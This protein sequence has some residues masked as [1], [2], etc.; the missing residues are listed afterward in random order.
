MIEDYINYDIFFKF[1]S[2]KKGYFRLIGMVSGGVRFYYDKNAEFVENLNELA[3]SLLDYVRSDNL[4]QISLSNKLFDKEKDDPLKF[5][6]I[7]KN[8]VTS[9]VRFLKDGREGVLD[10]ELE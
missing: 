9:L 3:D 5:Y 1:M 8:Y 4:N 10:V 6:P 2:E 7:S